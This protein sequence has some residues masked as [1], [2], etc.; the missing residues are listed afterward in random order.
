[1]KIKTHIP[2]GLLHVALCCAAIEGVIGLAVI[3]L[4]RWYRASH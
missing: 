1:M 4:W 2:L 3:A